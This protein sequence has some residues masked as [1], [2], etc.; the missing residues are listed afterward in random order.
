MRKYA[1]LLGA[2]ALAANAGAATIT[3]NLVD[4]F[5]RNSPFG[6]AFDGTNLHW[7]DPDGVITEMTTDGVDTGNTTT[8]PA[9]W[10]ELGWNGSQL[11]SAFGNTV[12]SFD[13]YTGLNLSTL[14]VGAPGGLINGLDYDHNE[15]WWAPDVSDVYR[16][17][18][19]G[20]F[21]GPNPFL[22]GG[23]GYSGVERVDV[24]ASTFLIVVNDASAP[25]R[26][27]VHDLS[28]TEIGCGT[29]P[30][31]RY[32]GLA[33]DGRYLYAADFF[34]SR[35]DKIDVLVNGASIFNPVPEPASILLFG[36]GA[37]G[38]V[39]FSRSRRRA[40]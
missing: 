7:S 36:A 17:D 27:C 25:R 35:I 15:I 26:L 33:F 16:F 11:V 14:T 38:L 23:G 5:D 32:E 2:V 13:R 21:A 31:S 19:A 6:L 8:N 3:L 4:S 20:A 37:A 1:I 39:L 22:G 29:L 18:S 28:A 30:N 10:S 24:G 40:S 34:D 9:G 12:Y